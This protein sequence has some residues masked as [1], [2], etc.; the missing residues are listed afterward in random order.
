[1]PRLKKK[2][3]G[4]QQQQQQQE[5]TKKQQEPTKTVLALKKFS[6]K[7]YGVI[8]W[9]FAPS[10]TIVVFDLFDIRYQKKCLN[11]YLHE[12]DHFPDT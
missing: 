2:E 7:F 1:M 8:V 3:E 6:C 12:I 4:E 11:D 9:H 5:P 10:M